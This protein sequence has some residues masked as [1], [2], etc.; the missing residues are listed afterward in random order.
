MADLKQPI[1]MSHIKSVV[2]WHVACR[3]QSY[4]LLAD[5]KWAVRFKFFFLL[6]RSAIYKNQSTYVRTSR[7]LLYLVA[8]HRGCSGFHRSNNL[9]LKKNSSIIGL[10]LHPVFRTFSRLQRDSITQLAIN[11]YYQNLRAEHCGQCCHLTGLLPNL[12]GFSRC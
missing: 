2:Q 5:A 11:C 6:R 7:V 3:L 12:G 10:K 9:R 1:W 4:G 8:T